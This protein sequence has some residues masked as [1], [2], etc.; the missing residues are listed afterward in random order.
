MNTVMDTTE[1]LERVRKGPFDFSIGKCLELSG[2]GGLPQEPGQ[3]WRV[4][5]RKCRA[6]EDFQKVLPRHGAHL[7][8]SASECFGQKIRIT[9]LQPAPTIGTKQYLVSP[10]KPQRALQACTQKQRLPHRVCGELP[11]RSGL[12]STAVPRGPRNPSYSLGLHPGLTRL[13]QG[14]LAP[15]VSAVVPW[16]SAPCRALH[17]VQPAPRWSSHEMRSQVTAFIILDQC[18]PKKQLFQ[19]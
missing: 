16:D 6:E 1:R 2:K 18:F 9:Q 12:S 7:L 15:G 14:A 10:V 8:Y 4:E 17:V 5:R 19:S 3:A 13:A 11:R